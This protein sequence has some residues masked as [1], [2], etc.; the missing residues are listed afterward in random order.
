MDNRLFRFVSLSSVPKVAL[1]FT[2]EADKRTKRLRDDPG[3]RFVE[4]PQPMTRFSAAEW[5]KTQ[6]QYASKWASAIAFELR[7]RK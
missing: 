7:T 5:L 1:R 6:P 2:N 4:L 3:I